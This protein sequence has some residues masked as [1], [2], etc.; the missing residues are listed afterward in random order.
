MPIGVEILIDFLMEVGLPE[1]L[2]FVLVGALVGPA[3]RKC[4]STRMTRPL[5][6]I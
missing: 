2:A 1:F 4:P 3:A 6:L 5:E